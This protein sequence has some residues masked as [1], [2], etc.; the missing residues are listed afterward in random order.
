LDS[1]LYV[2][3]LLT[4]SPP[5][6]KVQR[7]EQLFSV[8]VQAKEQQRQ[9]NDVVYWRKERTTFWVSDEHQDGLALHPILQCSLALFL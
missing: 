4:F 9:R 8:N 6:S 1:L 2:E 7:D 5:G 3:L